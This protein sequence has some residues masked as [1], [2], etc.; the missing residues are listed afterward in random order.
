VVGN[1][2]GGAVSVNTGGKWT[3]EDYPTEQFYH[4]AATTHIPYH[5][6]GA[7]QDNST[8]CIPF[9]WNAGRGGRRGGGDSGPS[10]PTQGGMEQAYVVGGGEPGYIAPDPRDPD[11]FYSGAN[12]GSYLDKFNRRLG[13]SREVNPY[14]WFY[15]GEPSS[16][17]RERWQWTYPIL[18]SPV[19]PK[20]LYVSSQRLWKTTD[21]GQT[22]T[23]LSGDLTRHDPKTQ[24]KSG[25][26]ITG[27]MNGP[28]VYATIFSVGPS[29][30]DVNVIWTGSDD[31]LV[32]VTRDGGKTWTNVTPPAC[33]SSAA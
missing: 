24:G 25:G 29:K 28:E 5:V 17:I 16:E 32:H 9:D 13:T 33:P 20:T 27:D 2:G 22:W 19:D 10:D 8:L 23:A 6:C 15:S 11:L 7:Q 3:E 1:D 12:N 21:G 26:P 30:R 18:F 31:G 14:P 4:I